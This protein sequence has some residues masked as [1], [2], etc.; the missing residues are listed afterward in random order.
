MHGGSL[1][2]ETAPGY[3]RALRS[4]P[5]AYEGKLFGRACRREALYGFAGKPACLP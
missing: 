5:F 1:P 4:E 3:V 2:R